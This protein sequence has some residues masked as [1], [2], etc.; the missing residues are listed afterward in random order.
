M[1]KRDGEGTKEEQYRVMVLQA[2]T[3]EG[4]LQKQRYC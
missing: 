3:I 4:I 1:A 2:M